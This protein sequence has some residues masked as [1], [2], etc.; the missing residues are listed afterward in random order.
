M[1]EK[2]LAEGTLQV[3]PD[4]GIKV[5]LTSGNLVDIQVSMKE[6]SLLAEEKKLITQL[7]DEKKELEK[8]IEWLSSLTGKIEDKRAGE[9]MKALLPTL[10]K[11]GFKELKFSAGIHE[12]NGKFTIVLLISHKNG[13]ASLSST[14]AFRPGEAFKRA[15]D[16]RN[17]IVDKINSL[18]K[19]LLSVKDQLNN[20]P[21]MERKARAQLGIQILETSELGKKL[22][23]NMQNPAK[24]LTVGK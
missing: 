3:T 19:Q 4:V 22:L 20:I 10:K 21:R 11:L 5:E 14:S 18:K 2:P 13:C 12:D 16:T 17:A 1:S 15:I 24:Q 23:G 9:T 8:A 6:E 7:D